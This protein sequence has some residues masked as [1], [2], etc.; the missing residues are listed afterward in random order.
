MHNHL[1]LFS[2]CFISGAMLIGVLLVP[3]TSHA[4]SYNC[5]GE[6]DCQSVPDA[7]PDVK[8]GK[9]GGGIQPDPTC[10][11][12]GGTCG[13]ANQCSGIIVEAQCPANTYCCVPIIINGGSGKHH[14]GGR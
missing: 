10:S 5:T 9:K 4:I 3:V 14:T 8:K 7:T 2:T 1:C 12:Q 6:Y 11:S 13:A